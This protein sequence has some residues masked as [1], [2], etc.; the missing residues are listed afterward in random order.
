[1]ITSFSSL[2]FSR[3]LV[4]AEKKT[5]DCYYISMQRV[6]MYD[7]QTLIKVGHPISDVLI[8]EGYKKLRILVLYTIVRN[9]GHSLFLYEILENQ[10][11]VIEPIVELLLPGVYRNLY[12]L[13]GNPMILIGTPYMTRQ[14]RVQKIHDFKNITFE[15]SLMTGHFVKLASLF[16]DRWWIITMAIDGIIYVRDKTVRREVACI[17]VHHREELGTKKAM[18]NKQGD[19]IIALG[20]NGSLIATKF[21][22]AKKVF[23]YA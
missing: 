20:Y 2:S 7:V 6:N 11:L 9:V 3:S 4:A 19:L 17:K 13:P 18:I 14:L 23:T 5:G 15:D 12:H 10:T 22:P 8:F 1:M 16:V 21:S